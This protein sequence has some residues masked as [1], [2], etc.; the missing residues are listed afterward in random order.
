MPR[1]QISARLT[2]REFI[3]AAGAAVIAAGA[4]GDAVS[5]VRSRKSRLNLVIVTTDDNDAESLGCFG[6]TLREVTPNMDRL[7]ADGVR[8]AHAYTTSPTCQPS[9]L[10]LMTGRYPQTNGSIG[11]SEP[12]KPGVTTLA[13]ELKKAGYYTAIVGKQ[14]NYVPEDAFDWVR[15]KNETADDWDDQSDGYWSMWRSPEGFYKGTK[16]LLAEAAK[17]DKPFFLHLNTSDPHRPWPGSVDEVEFLQRLEK[18]F[19]RK[20]TPM[21]PYSRNY[22]PYEVPV[23]GYLPDLPGVRVDVAQYYS[24][25]H[26]AD[27]AVGRIFDAL[28]EAGA[29]D[30]TIVICFGDQGAPFPM[31]KQNL[32]PVSNRIPLI[33]RWPG[34][35][36]PGSVVND[37]VSIIDI[38]PTLI[39][40]LGLESV[41]EMD[42]R[43]FLGLM[44]GDGSRGRDYV[45][46]SYNYARPGVQAFPMRAVQSKDFIYIYNAWHGESNIAPKHPLKYDGE[47]DPLTG[48]CWK[49]MK[50]ATASDAA[51]AKRVEFIINRV[52]EEF[53][54]LR[55]DPYCLENRIADPADARVIAD[56]KRILEQHMERTRDPLLAKFRGT[57]PIPPEWLTVRD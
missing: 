13:R 34:V 38:M 52:S 53:Y 18:Q 16:E 40:G 19:G 57:G 15:N 33:I 9:R 25:L 7:A 6:C 29:W 31:S 20:A 32:Y 17:S 45:F 48:L 26:N 1:S 14:P 37:M 5:D 42:G 3:K 10:S 12:L 54:D 35:T 28:K 47:I 46:T 23:P 11:H 43:S 51:I 4:R 36:R 21:R 49:S 44:T 24:A 41:S 50:E 39:E 56:M 30:N 22:S 55:R 2:R 8:F 27:R